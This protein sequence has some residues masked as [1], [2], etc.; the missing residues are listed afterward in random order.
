MFPKRFF[1]KRYWAG[2]FWTPPGTRITEV[3]LSGTSSPVLTGTMHVYDFTQANPTRVNISKRRL[4][5]MIH[6]G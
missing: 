6:Y 4:G 3:A 5:R 2:R 1:S